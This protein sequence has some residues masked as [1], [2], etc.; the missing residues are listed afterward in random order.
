[1]F[2]D[3]SAKALLTHLMIIVISCNVSCNN[4]LSSTAEVL[5]YP[6]SAIAM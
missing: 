3:M 2:C 1:M 4:I 6:P 5:I